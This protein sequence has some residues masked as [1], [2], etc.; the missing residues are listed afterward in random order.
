MKSFIITTYL[1]LVSFLGLTQKG[2]FIE[3]KGQWDNKVLFK[4]ELKYGSFFIEKDGFT[5]NVHDPNAI[6]HLF[7]HKH[8]ISSHHNKSFQQ[9]T[10]KNIRAHAFTIK[11]PNAILNKFEAQSD[12]KDYSINYFKGNNPEKWASNL[13]PLNSIIFK[14]IYPLIDLKV[15]FSNN[16]I[17]YDFILLPNADPKK[18]TVQYNHL[19]QLQH[20]KYQIELNTNVGV[21]YDENPI[22]Y[23]KSNP[24]KKIKTTFERLDS[25]TFH[26]TAGFSKITETLVIDPKLNFATF[27]GAFFDNWGYTA[28]YDDEGNGYAGGIT[29]F[30]G[31]PTTLGAYQTN[32]GGGDI[33]I[34]I[35][36]FSSDGKELLYSTYIGG[37]GLEA[38]HSMIVNSK[39]ELAIYGV[40]SSTNYPTSFNGFNQNFNGG[41]SVGASNVLEF[42]TGTDIILTVLNKDGTGIVGSTYFGGSKNDGIND[43]EQKSHLYK[44]YADVYRGEI[45]TDSDD[46]LII[47]SVTSS[48]D[49]TIKNGFQSIFGGGNQD[50]C[51][52]K[53]SSDLS[54]LHW[55]SFFGGNGDDAC[56][57]NKL[58]SLEEIYITGGTTSSNLSPASPGLVK[59][60]KNNIDG[61]LAKISSDGATLDAL[62]YIGTEAY[63]Q[64]YFVEVDFE[65]N[66][67]CFGQS[68]GK[69]ETVGDVYYNK[70][71]HQFLQ[72]YSFDL[73][74]LI[75][76]TTIG[77]GN[78]KINIVPDAFMV[79]NCKEVYLSGWGGLSNSDS[80]G[81]INMPITRD[82]IQKTTDGSDFYFMSLSPDFKTLKYASYFGGKT[83]Q[84]HVDGGTSRFDKTGTIYQ[85]VCGGCGGSSAFPVSARAYSTTNNSNNCN[86]ALIK[87]DISKLTANL[88][89][90]SDSSYCN[91]DPIKFKNL[92]TGGQEY[93]WIYPDGSSSVGFDGEYYFEDSGTFEMKLIAYDSTQCPFSD[94]IDLTIDV[95]KIP[96]ITIA[97]DTFLCV[98]NSLEIET[99]GGPIDTNYT[100][101]T[102][103]DTFSVNGPNLFIEPKQT[104]DYFVKYEN[105]CGANIQKVNIP[106]YVNPKNQARSDTICEGQLPKFEFQDVPINTVTELNG[107]YFKLENNQISFKSEKS[108]IYYI[109]TIGSCGNSIDTFNIDY[110][111]INPFSGPDTIICPG[112]TVNLFAGG[113]DSLIWLETTFENK[114]DSL[115]FNY[116]P[117]LTQNL[118]VKI[119][120]RSCEEVDTVN[121]KIYPTPVQPIEKEYN[122]NYG[123]SVQLP[124][125][126]EFSYSWFP[127]DFL[128][129]ERCHNPI[130]KPEEDIKYYF[131]Y[132]SEQSCY[133][134]DSVTINVIF[135]LYIANTFTPN[136]DGKNDVF[137]AY[138]HLIKE[139]EITIYDRWGMA[140]Y[141]SNDI[142]KGWDG[143]LNGVQQQQD[144][145][146]YIMKYTKVHTSK[147]IRRVGTVNLIR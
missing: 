12:S 3:N 34:S 75:A 124:L 52:A 58:N 7:N 126:N 2:Y 20:S 109:Q 121:I 127:S 110:P 72:K 129:C 68:S 98:N 83:L 97:I 107:K 45:T 10:S 91:N 96:D 86:L 134:T 41:D 77:S 105:I 46:N 78:G 39:G 48:P 4:A 28:T 49:L 27:T 17:K 125:S 90:T 81:T 16:A 139:F 66:I 35:S 26:L 79:S 111:E 30:G 53:F 18:V 93:K 63:D 104:S 70:K 140:I 116:Q 114:T 92:S 103:T 99:T 131:K 106:V 122:I 147:I 6:D 19:S 55:S 47:A 113:G 44:N 57:A 43:P 54:Q 145:F 80:I 29:F 65:D 71:S 62:T 146:V 8:E 67:Y 87:M 82:A 132:N 108:D 143:T 32:Y 38:P 36:K 115:I 69:M 73:S 14:N 56:Y 64:S 25:N 141:Q 74:Q 21:I 136:G 31:Y 76:A 61:F 101:W 37:S 59:T 50:G 144:V 89:F 120:K 85:A 112:E 22:S 137:Y 33:D 5:I 123:E 94:T 42:K 117:A 142:T 95:I 100:W 11:F 135:P 133:I 51:V 128:N 13:H 84:E 60:Y 102:P 119:I 1:L 40:S 130:T 138:S 15:Y 88:K 9:P 23:F 24:H 118:L